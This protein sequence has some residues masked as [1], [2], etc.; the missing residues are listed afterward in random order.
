MS[1]EAIN[2]VKNEFLSRREITCNFIGLAGKLKKLEAI[3][4]VNKKFKLGE[5]IIIPMRLQ[6][7]VGKPLVTGTFYVYDD[8]KLAKAHINPVIFAR[9]EKAKKTNEEAQAKPKETTEPEPKE[10]KP[11]ETKEEKPAEPKE[12]KPAEPKEEKPAEPKEEKPAETKADEKKLE[13]KSE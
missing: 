13:E 11:V 8:E 7:H 3:D 12:E 4:M 6:N 10:E 5:K 2:D 9:L 1:I